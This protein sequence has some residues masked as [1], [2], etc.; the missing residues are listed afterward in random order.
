MRILRLLLAMLAIM[1]FTCPGV[2]AQPVSS[3]QDVAFDPGSQMV[4]LLSSAPLSPRIQYL[5]DN[6]PGK[7][8]LDMPNSVFPRVKQEIPAGGSA[9]DK[10]RVSQFQ[11][12]PPSVRL[13]L[14]LA[15][16]LEVKVHTHRVSGGYET[17]IGPADAI[18]RS[19]D[20]SDFQVD[21]SNPQ[22]SQAL[23]KEQLEPPA[24]GAPLGPQLEK[25]S[26]IQSYQS[27]P[28]AAPA[29]RIGKP[30]LLDL[31]IVGQNLV[32]EGNAPIYP[33]MR[34]LSADRLEYLL[35]L[36]DF[37]TK[38]D[39]LQSRLQS[40]LLESATVLQDGKGVQIRLRLRRADIE[41]IPFS[42]DQFCTLQFLAKA[43]ERDLAH[44]SDLQVEDLDKQTTR[45]RL[46]ADKAF[47]YQIYPLENP[48][49]LVIDTLGTRLGN[50]ALESK[51]IKSANVKGV[52]F[53]P[54]Q[55]QV[56]SD[57]RVVLDL[58]GPA[59]YQFDWKGNYLEITLAGKHQAVE[60]PVQT[61]QGNFRAFVV[62]DAGHG[63]NDPGAI[64]T[65]GVREKDVT[66]AVSQYL[67]RYLQ[68]DRLQ[69][70]LTRQEDLEVL[71]QPRVDVANLRHADLFVS[72]HCNSMPPNNA[73][74]RGLETYYTN[75]QS[76]ELANTLHKY[77]VSELGA[78]DRRVRQRGLYVT[79][80]TVM[81]GVLM[82]I[83]FLS[84]PEEE[85]LLNDP[86]YQRRVAKALRDGIFDYLSRHQKLQPQG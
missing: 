86:N 9:I 57:L 52:R 36:Y 48:S 40:P 44:F 6:Q 66:L 81:P 25:P 58:Y 76:L 70:V 7:I 19:S 35:T 56:Q 82:E 33:E 72:I 38:L 26:A 59:V 32:M 3:I 24:L 29:P 27:K 85:A 28:M 4:K 42:A 62:V 14:D 15:A 67:A 83:G 51:L 5:S 54:T 31:R 41:L 12:S 64:G 69:V 73:G 16:A 20:A 53:I 75:P 30:E 60:P 84:N 22:D 2:I 50:K 71:L 47:D 46:Y 23:S 63:G 77:L 17:R 21:S 45:I 10:I 43:S 65:R 68:D 74:V 61:P 37:T 8:V 18:D 80:K 39:G 1:L 55:T 11:N 79:H 34:Q 78:P 49:R 13:V